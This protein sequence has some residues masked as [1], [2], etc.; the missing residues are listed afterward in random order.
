MK[1]L[2]KKWDMRFL[3][4]CKHISEW[5]HDPSTKVGSVI[6]RPNRQLVSIGFNGFA[7]D[8]DDSSKRYENRE[9]KYDLI[10]HS[11]ENAMIFADRD[12]LEGAC[13]YVYPF[14]PC[15]RCGAKLIQSGIKRVVSIKSDNP[16]WVENF[17]LTTDQFKE[18]EVELVLYEDIE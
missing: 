4:L 6:V 14:M 17:I 8:V 11:E 7:Q 18:A 16:R 1:K 2:D 12:K 10:I 13:I 3:K 9:V 5:S 15:S